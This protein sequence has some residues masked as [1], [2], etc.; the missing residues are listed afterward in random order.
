M[1]TNFTVVAYKTMVKPVVA[2]RCETWAVVEV[3]MK[4]LNTWE[5]KILRIT[6]GT[7]RDMENKH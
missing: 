6:S 7:A 2:Y 3:D 1:L 5:R 4:R